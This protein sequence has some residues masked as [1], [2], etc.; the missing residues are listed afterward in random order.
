M[1]DT[2]TT[3][4]V[5]LSVGALLRPMLCY[6]TLKEDYGLSNNDDVETGVIISK[7][8]A[9]AAGF[10]QGHPRAHQHDDALSKARFELRWRNQFGISLDPV[11]A[12]RVLR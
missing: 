12:G 8:A 7:I 6:V 3:M 11:I 9:H 5:P 1:N 10:A 2:W 4:N